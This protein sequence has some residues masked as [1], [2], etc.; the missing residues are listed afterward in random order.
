[1]VTRN[2]HPRRYY[3]KHRE[4]RL[5]YQKKY[6]WKNRENIRKEQNK[7][8]KSPPNKLSGF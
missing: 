5:K 6:Y 1:M 3:A 7:R 2:T 8:S 4:E